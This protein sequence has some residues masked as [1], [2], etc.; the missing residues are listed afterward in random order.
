[1]KNWKKGLTAAVVALLLAALLLPA[2]GTS[3]TIYLMAVNDKVLETTAENMPMTVNGTLYV[4]YTML[5][6]RDLGFN[7]GVSAQ[8]NN[9]RRTVLVSSEGGQKGVIF[10][11]QANTAQDLSGASLTVRAMMRNSTVFLPIDWICEYFGII[12]CARIST[13]HGTLIRVTNSAAILNEQGFVNAADS[14]LADNL[15]RYLAS[16]GPV[17]GTDPAPSG[18]ASASAAPSQAELYLALRWGEGAEDCARLLEGR[19]Q[20]AL[21]LFAPEEL[22]AHDDLVRRL[23]GAGHTVGLALAGSE[24]E[25]CLEQLEEGRRLLAAIARY[26]ALVAA[27]P[28]LDK[29]GR[30]ALAQAGCAVWSA[31]ALGTDYASGGA[32]IRGLTPKRMNYVELSCSGGASAFLRSALT[33]MEEEN[34]R[35][36]QATAP[37]LS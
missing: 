22:E 14:Q 27:A 33:A 18:E 9:T 24:L 10:D 31:T 20:R 16:G 17:D 21:F 19:G 36:Y 11:L 37:A 30:E 25:D 5:S 15:S 3:G 13:R 4:P 1:M 26:P 8:Y 29:A 35:V 23:V 2:F 7:L 28:D 34:C 12:T 6:S 32:L